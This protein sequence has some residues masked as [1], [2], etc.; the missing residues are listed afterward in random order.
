MMKGVRLVSAYLRSPCYIIASALALDILEA[1][2]TVQAYGTNLP[3][4]SL[5]SVNANYHLDHQLNVVIK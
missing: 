5:I 3:I 4:H 2:I 1:L